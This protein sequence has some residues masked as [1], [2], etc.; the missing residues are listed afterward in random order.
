MISN[1]RDNTKN[2]K[3]VI[4]ST[5][6][7]GVPTGTNGLTIA[8]ISGNHNKVVPSISIDTKNVAILIGFIVYPPN[9]FA[10]LY[11]SN[12]ILTN[13]ATFIAISIPR[14]HS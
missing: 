1:I 8:I 2:G 6:Q 4:K 3:K 9:G 14:N 13:K 12:T 5:N 11:I 7:V 10:A